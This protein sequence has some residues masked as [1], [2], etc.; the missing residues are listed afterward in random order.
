MNRVFDLLEGETFDRTPD[1][2]VVGYLRQ[3]ECKRRRH[4]RDPEHDPMRCHH[5]DL[6]ERDLGRSCLDVVRI[7]VDESD[8]GLF[9]RVSLVHVTGGTRFTTLGRSEATMA[10]VTSARLR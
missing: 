2:T 8:D 6:G 5:R 1:L 9:L 7:R 10:P 4:D 3:D